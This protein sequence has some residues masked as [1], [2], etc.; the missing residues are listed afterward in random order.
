M[1][2]LLGKCFVSLSMANLVISYQNTHLLD[3]MLER[4]NKWSRKVERPSYT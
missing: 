1:K 3:L 4:T 2:Y